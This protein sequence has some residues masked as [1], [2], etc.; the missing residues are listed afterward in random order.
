M[1]NGAASCKIAV[2]YEPDDITSVEWLE[3]RA[4]GDGFVIVDTPVYAVGLSSGDVVSVTSWDEG[5][6]VSQ[7]VR[8][9]GFATFRV[10]ANDEAAESRLVMDLLQRIV[11]TG[12]DVYSPVRLL[13]T[14]N[15]RMGLSLDTTLRILDHGSTQ[16]L[17]DYAIGNIPIS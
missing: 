2:F 14:V 10:L 6:R 1:S 4:N 8:S 15:V 7:I 3:A 16:G 5:L 9:G 17:W 13:Y 12:A 11:D